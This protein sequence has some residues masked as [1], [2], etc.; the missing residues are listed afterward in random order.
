MLDDTRH[1]E[2]LRR[3]SHLDE[4]AASSPKKEGEVEGVEASCG[5]FGYLRGIRDQSSRRGVPL[6]RRQQRLVPVLVAGAVAV[7]SIGQDLLLKFSGDLVYLVLIRGSNLDRPLNEG[8][9]QPHPCR[10]ATASGALGPRDERGGE[11]AGGRKGADHRQHRSGG[12][13]DPLRTQGMAGQA[14]PGVRAVIRAIFA[15]KQTPPRGLSILE[16]CPRSES[17]RHILADTGF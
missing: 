9:H 7:Q 5:A 12:I 6:P 11:P 15:R 13:R 10:F 2:R 17:N 8:V 14:R 1:Q 3:N 4:H 16:W